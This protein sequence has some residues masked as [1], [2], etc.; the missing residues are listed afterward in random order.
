MDKSIDYQMLEQF[1]DE[2][3]LRANRVIKDCFLKIKDYDDS[4]DKTREEFVF[5]EF[6]CALFFEDFFDN[7]IS[8]F[9]NKTEAK[10]EI[11]E[12][13]IILME[14]FEGNIE[15]ID[16]VDIITNDID[17][18]TEEEYSVYVYPYSRKCKAEDEFYVCCDNNVVPLSDVDTPEEYALWS[19][20]ISNQQRRK[21][22]V[23]NMNMDNIDEKEKKFNLKGYIRKICKKK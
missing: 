8:S 9:D 22:L 20:K 23:I 18:D 10:M 16:L 1:S 19:E 14:A 3:I 17:E 2:D 11:V 21:A 7:F 13:S 6:E 4:L 15:I 5:E 12:S